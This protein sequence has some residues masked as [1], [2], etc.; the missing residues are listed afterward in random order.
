VESTSSSINREIRK[1]T[2][3]KLVIAVRTFK[4][5]NRLKYLDSSTLKYRRM[6]GD[7]IQVYKMFTGK[8]DLTVTS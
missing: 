8:Y 4:Y 6:T 7:M 5:E 1:G 3:K 2:E